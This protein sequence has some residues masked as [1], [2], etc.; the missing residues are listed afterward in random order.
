[1]RGPTIYDKIIATLKGPS[2]P[3]TFAELITRLD[4]NYST[5]RVY[6]DR[7]LSR[8]DLKDADI[9]WRIAPKVV[10]VEVAMDQSGAMAS[11]KGEIQALR[12]ENAKL[13]EAQGLGA[14]NED[15]PLVPYLA[16]ILKAAGEELVAEAMERAFP[17][18]AILSTGELAAQEA[19][20]EAQGDQVMGASPAG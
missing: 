2:P 5:A 12:E 19:A 13:R 6:L 15:K 14:K 11:Y 9:P 3:Q 16:R 18:S 17:P 20:G 4:A 10:E 1:M 8:G 7:A